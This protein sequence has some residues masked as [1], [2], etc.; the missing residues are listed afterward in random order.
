[1]VLGSRS[2]FRSTSIGFRVCTVITALAITLPVAS[3]LAN[4]QTSV[5]ACE[6][7]CTSTDNQCSRYRGDQYKQCVKQC[8]TSCVPHRTPPPLLDLGCGNQK[9]TGKIKCTIAQPP[10]N[11]HETPVPS[12]LF[13]PGDVVDIAADG[14]V[15]TGGSGN[16]WK[17]YV[18]PSGS[19]SES[20]YHGMIRIPT[21]TP[22]SALVEVRSLIGQ[23]LL[24]SGSADIPASQMMLHLG[25][26][27]DDYSDNGYNDHDD[28]TE[29]QC[30]IGTGLD[31]GPAH[32]TL[33]IYRGVRP[34]PPQ[35][36]YDFDVLS[37]KVDPNGLPFNPEWSWQLR[38]RDNIPDTEMCHNF[39]IREWSNIP[40]NPGAFMSPYFADCTDQADMS[41]VDLPSGVNEVLCDARSI[42]YYGDT[43]PGHVNWFP[44]TLEGFGGWI[45]LGPDD[46]YTFS[47]TREDNSCPLCVNARDFVHVE[48]DSDE[49]IDHF[50]S[51]EW[52]Q[53]HKAVDDWM[54]AA[55][56]VSYC[57]TRGGCDLSE[58][59]Q[60]QQQVDALPKFFQGHTD[61]TGMFGL[62]GEHGLKS[63]LHP[64]FAVALRRDKIDNNQN[65]EGWLMF[66]RNQGDEGFCSSHIWGLGLEDYTF[67][68][69][70]RHPMLAVDVD[71]NKTA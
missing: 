45:T 22:N 8:Q 58:V 13:A 32:I 1:M 21:G 3:V 59:R 4:A 28:G 12:V 11:Q 50:S 23:R 17:R 60:A 57:E 30:K 16:T 14:C 20:L 55:G 35:S 56:I 42:P 38:H 34:D 47:Y 29:D 7:A 64:L 49:T 39:S 37:T 70:W 71:R 10:V 6:S 18:N 9:I 41:T 67:R 5:T 63:E 51:T 52:N 15:Q 33:T 65:D 25:Y 46:D 27:D 69:P 26:Q 68:L 66:V 54:S 2:C 40:P 19:N 48:F 36:G 43:F 31:G 24:V 62:D 61:L 44:V 53:L